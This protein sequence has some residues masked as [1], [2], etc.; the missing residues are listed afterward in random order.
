MRALVDTHVLLWWLKD[1]ERLSAMARDVLAD[2]DSHLLWSMASS[3]EIAVKARTGKLRL[4]R[5]IERLFGEIVGRQG[6]EILPITHE[7]CGRVARLPLHH[8]D[9]FD[10]M[11]VAQANQEKV[12]IVSADRKL[13]QYRVETIW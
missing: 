11:L 4:G 13:D 7:H 5:P 8:R 9:P 12:P 1:D 10:R 6:L 3:W 2:G